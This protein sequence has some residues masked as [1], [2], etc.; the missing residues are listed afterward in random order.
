VPVERTTV[1]KPE[2]GQ[3]AGDVLSNGYYV[4]TIRRSEELQTLDGMVGVMTALMGTTPAELERAD[5]DTEGEFE[6]MVF[7]CDPDG[8]VQSWTE[9]DFRRYDTEDEAS[10][11]HEWLVKMWT[12]R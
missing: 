2:A 9:L 8:S 5:L 3:L 11:G 1:T 7:R 12:G 4:S 10:E 6:S